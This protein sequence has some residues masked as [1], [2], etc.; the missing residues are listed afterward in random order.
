MD[1]AEADLLAG[2]LNAVECSKQSTGRVAKAQE[3]VTA[4]ARPFASISDLT[5]KTRPCLRPMLFGARVH[6]QTGSE[7]C[8]RFMLGLGSVLAA[9]PDSSKQCLLPMSMFPLTVE[10]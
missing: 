2:L 7:Q 8:H 5:T 6:L 3:E 10:Q 4:S 1:G 9:Y